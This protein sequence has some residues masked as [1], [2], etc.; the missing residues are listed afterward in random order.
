[1]TREVLS[2]QMGPKGIII[3]ESFAAELAEGV[4]SEGT[5]ILHQ[6]RER[7]SVDDDV[8]IIVATRHRQT[9]IL[10]IAEQQILTSNLVVAISQD[11]KAFVYRYHSAREH[12]TPEIPC[13]V[14]AAVNSWH[15]LK[16][17]ESGMHSTRPK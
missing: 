3:V 4:S 7:T 11:S 12:K 8:I 2:P 5:P 10:V 9:S 15:T 13:N 1:M 14:S 17:K 6:E 16:D